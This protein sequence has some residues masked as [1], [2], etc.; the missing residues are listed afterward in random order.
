[1]SL[2]LEPVDGIGE[3]RPGDDLADLVAAR[4]QLA[5]GDVL[6]VTSK[7]V[8]K[9][10]GLA[11][12][13][14]RDE[15]IAAQTDR[16]VARRGPTSIVR[17]HHGLTMAA[18]GVDNSNTEPGTLIP[19]PPDPDAS[20]ATIRRRILELTGVRVAVII[21]DTA[22]R[23]WR[24]GQTDIAIGC[25]GIAPLDSF[26]GRTDTYGN[27]LAVTAP[28]VADEIAGAAELASGKLGGRPVVLVRGVDPA[29]LSADD[30]VGAGALLRD[31]A[32]DMFGLGAREAAVAAITGDGPV[33]GLPADDAITVDDLVE[34]ALRGVTFPRQRVSIT[35][36]GVTVEA[37]DD[38]VVAGAVAQRLTSLGIAFGMTI[39]VQVVTST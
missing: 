36:A 13:V 38:Q 16:L 34:L 29:W 31:E 35:G 33:R 39:G 23:A 18:A 3:V 7:V 11:T 19:L 17:T 10:A 14:P 15:L 2:T 32:S 9:A 5:D 24:V 12:T 21:S 30:G 4:T 20:A 27:L 22:G 25:A 37:G 28:A 26:A 8:S 6:V 1:M